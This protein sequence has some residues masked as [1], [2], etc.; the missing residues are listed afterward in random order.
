MSSAKEKEH[1]SHNFYANFTLINMFVPHFEQ[2]KLDGGKKDVVHM[3]SGS[4]FTGGKYW[5][6]FFL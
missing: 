1:I 5:T 2:H 6:S 4:H 3:N